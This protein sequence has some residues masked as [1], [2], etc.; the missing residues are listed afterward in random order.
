MVVPD[1]SNPESKKVQ[2]ESMFDSIAPKYDL[3][4]HTLSLN[5][6]K[7]WRRKVARSVAKNRPG[8]VLDVATGTCDL[9]IAVAR[10]ARPQSI[11][12]ID[13]SEEM[14][15]VGRQKVQK[16]NLSDT[17]TVQKGDA[18]NLPFGDNTFDA[19]TVAFGVRN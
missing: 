4:N 16:I 17:I 18:E 2:V 19:I 10:K 14:L 5:I 6:D 12:G 11:V 7:I 8:T 1:Q 9:A 3:L 13:L 15:N